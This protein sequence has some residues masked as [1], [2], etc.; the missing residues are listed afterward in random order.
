MEE[1]IIQKMAYVVTF[2]KPPISKEY[3][4]FQ[5]Y[6]ITQSY[7]GHEYIPS[8]TILRI[9]TNKPMALKY[10]EEQRS[11]YQSFI[12]ECKESYLFDLIQSASPEEK[13]VP[14]KNPQTSKKNKKE[15]Q[16]SSNLPP[17]AT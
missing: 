10:L 14:S 17:E 4:V 7:P 12:L 8:R 15:F 3:P 9:F 11:S 16:N 2:R 5:S 1:K 6:P 13:E